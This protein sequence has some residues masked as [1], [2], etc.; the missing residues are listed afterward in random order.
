MGRRL[1]PAS[2]VALAA[3]ADAHGAHGLARTALLAAVPLAAVAAIASIGACL[4]ERQEP[5]M[6]AQAA[7]SGVIVVLLVASCAIRADAV[8]GIPRIAISSGLAA[9]ALFCLQG[10]L[11]ALPALARIARAW[12]AKP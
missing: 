10:A 6:I 9:L 7:L 1:L 5:S 2:L 8:V 12:P 11:T 3:L 4:E